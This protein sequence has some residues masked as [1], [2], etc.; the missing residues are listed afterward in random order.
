MKKQTLTITFFES[1]D[2]NRQGQ[3]T[4][5][6]R[7]SVE[8][9][10]PDTSNLNKD[11]RDFVQE[12]VN[13]HARKAAYDQVTWAQKQKLSADFDIDN[14]DTNVPRT[15]K[16]SFSGHSLLENPDNLAN[17]HQWQELH[18]P[19][20]TR[21][22]INTLKTDS[23][24]L[25]VVGS[26]GFA[27]S[28]IGAILGGG[29]LYGLVSESAGDYGVAAMGALLLLSIALSLIGACVEASASRVERNAREDAPGLPTVT[30]SRVTLLNND[31]VV[32]AVPVP[33]EPAKHQ[34]K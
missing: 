17:K 14:A 26:S 34:V 5:S 12:F 27:I 13:Q 30:V 15:F 2:K 3:I 18:F 23:E 21:K 9:D 28:F 24:N 20:A 33:D 29:L 1:A 6:E 8:I 22:R 4:R 32:T 25:K 7:Y 19:E 31:S 11:K 10:T 16:Q